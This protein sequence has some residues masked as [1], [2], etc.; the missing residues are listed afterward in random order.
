MDPNQTF[1]GSPE[2]VHAHL[3]IML[4][5]TCSWLMVQSHRTQSRT[6]S[7][8][9][10]LVGEVGRAIVKFENINHSRTQGI[11]DMFM[12]HGII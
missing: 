12:V 8:Q 3:G 4:S 11:A 7:K 1:F 10:N 5:P 6:E 9:V 2:D